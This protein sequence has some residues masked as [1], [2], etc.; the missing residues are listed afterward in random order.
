M[1][2]VII[3]HKNHG[4]DEVADALVLAL[5]DRHD[6]EITFKTTSEIANEEF[7][8]DCLKD[9]FNYKDLKECHVD[10]DNHRPI[11]FR[12][13]SLFNRKNKAEFVKLVLS[14][15]GVYAGLRCILEL[16]EAR[17]QKLFDFLIAVDATDRLPEEPKSSFTIPLTEAEFIL[18]NNGTIEELR[19]KVN[20]L[21][22][23]LVA[24]YKTKNK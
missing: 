8:F 5:K 15:Y 17:K 7:V 9:E 24:S 10:R 19:P 18:D 6:I 23:W 4:K 21:A 13:I 2:I 1:N 20:E 11:W 3:G 22:D 16:R 12:L 14:K